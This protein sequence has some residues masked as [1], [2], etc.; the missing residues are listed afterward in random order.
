[1]RITTF[2]AIVATATLAFGCATAAADDD[3]FRP[4]VITVSG[5][6]TINTDPDRAG[7]SFGVEVQAETA[8]EAQSRLAET[9]NRVLEAMDALRLSE[10]DLKTT[11]VSL[12][13][14]YNRADQE[15]GRPARVE[16]YS[17]SNNVRVRFADENGVSSMGGIQF[18]LH[19]DKELRL[20]ALKE[21]VKNAKAKA[22]SLAEGLGV[23]LGDVIA[24]N[25]GGGGIVPFQP[26]FEARMAFSTATTRPLS[27]TLT[28][29]RRG[30][31]T[32]MEPTCVIGILAP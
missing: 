21:A 12:R 17:A 20:D 26:R 16:G 15:K 13:T 4:P 14:I 5:E 3:D 2:S 9:V 31:G 6:S 19:D 27:H 7:V 29:R 22:E 18:F 10:A 11:G 24:V 30:S 25:E 8:A 1:M 32:E 28:C 23:E